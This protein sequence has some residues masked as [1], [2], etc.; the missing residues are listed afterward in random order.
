MSLGLLVGD[1]QWVVGSPG[2]LH[3]F[4]STVSV[5]LE[6]GGW[7]SRFP[8]LMDELYQGELPVTSVETAL[9]ELLLAQRE[10]S[11][12]P[13]TGLVWDADDPGARSSW[14]DAVAGGAPDLSRCFFTQEGRDLFDVLRAALVRLRAQPDGAMRI[15]QSGGAG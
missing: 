11:C 5:R 14:A 13:A 7:G 10:L 12:L 9:S 1:D 2:L 8:A 15:V 6:H 4:F 3:A